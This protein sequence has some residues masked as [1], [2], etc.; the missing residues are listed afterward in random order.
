MS[1]LVRKDGIGIKMI[2]ILISIPFL[3]C[4]CKKKSRIETGITILF[5]PLISFCWFFFSQMTE[6]ILI[7]RSTRRLKDTKTILPTQKP[8]PPKRGKIMCSLILAPTD[9][10]DIKINKVCTEMKNVHQNRFNFPGKM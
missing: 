5:V 7:K 8:F 10:S 9:P 2:I 3:V 1:H 4:G 6:N